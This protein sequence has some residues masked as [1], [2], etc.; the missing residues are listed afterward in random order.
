MRFIP[1][2]VHAVLDYLMG[3][4]LI[5]APWMFGFAQNGAETWVPVMLGVG[6]LIYSMC[7]NYEYG[8]F[9]LLSV[10]AHLT[11]DLLGGLFLAASPWIF[12]FAD[13]VYLPHLILGILEVGASLMTRRV[14]QE[15]AATNLK[16]RGRYEH[17]H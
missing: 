7:T 16:N 12:G 1:T 13:Y 15:G 5:V 10:P 11:I 3:M 4:L 9:K 17:A 6:M 2:R 8:A 14:P